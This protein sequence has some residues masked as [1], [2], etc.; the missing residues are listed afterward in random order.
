MIEERIEVKEVEEAVKKG[1]CIKCKEL[2]LSK[3]HRK[4]DEE[5][6]KECGICGECVDLICGFEQYKEM[7]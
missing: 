7:A 4:V 6:Y 2:A 3:N 1:I 5:F